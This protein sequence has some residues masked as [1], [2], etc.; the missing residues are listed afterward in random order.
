[1]KIT[2]IGCGL[3][4]GSLA[5]TLKRRRPEYT[6]ACLDLTERIP[7]IIEAGVADKVGSIDN[8]DDFAAYIPES[9]LVVIATPVQFVSDTLVKLKPFLKKNTIVTDVGS[10]K[11]RIM[12][13]APEFL[14]ADV[15]FIG[16]HPMAGGE[17]SG[18]EAAD[19]LLF[20]DKVYAICPYPTTPPEALLTLIELVESLGAVPVTIDAEEHDRIVAMVSHLPHFISTALMHAAMA[21]DAEHSMLEKMAGRGFLDMTRLAASDYKM[22]Q[23]IMATNAEAISEAMDSFNR[24]L[25]FITQGMSEPDVQGAWEKAV[26]KRR[27]MT[28]ESLP[29][30]RRQDLRT[31]IDRQDKMLMSMLAR[32]FDAVRKIGKLKMHQ[33]MPVVDS[34]R[35]KRMM[36]ERR[37]WGKSLG[38]PEEMIEELFSVILKHSSQL[39]EMES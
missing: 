22:W 26:Q 13:E 17:R 8:P 16:G 23:G 37:D 1:M 9:D 32:R 31:V 29:R 25:V 20:S 18:V 35:E 10:T 34:D 21:E 36:V 15:C 3:I 6:I 14:P 24:S 11:N 30:S 4:G 12:T 38:L 2:V 27:T 33:A 28:P 7:A 19:P 39:Q 5:L